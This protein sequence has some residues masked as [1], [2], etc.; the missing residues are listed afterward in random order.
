MLQDGRSRIRFPMRLFNF[1]VDL[2]LP[3][4]LW[5]WDRLQE[6]SRSVKRGRRVRMTS[7]PSVSRLSRK[8]GSLDLPQPYG[9]PLPVTVIAL[10]FI[11]M[12]QEDFNT[13]E[14]CE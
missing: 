9:P 10:P 7:P 6:F 11:Y 13:R 5:P 1:S 12:Y 14:V 2:I 8:C 4:A 3:A